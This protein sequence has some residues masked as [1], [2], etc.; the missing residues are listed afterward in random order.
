MITLVSVFLLAVLLVASAAA[1]VR[2]ERAARREYETAGE[3][4]ARDLYD[5]YQRD[6]EALT[7]AYLLRAAPDEEWLATLKT[8]AATPG[9]PGKD[10]RVAGPVPAHGVSGYRP[11]ST[12][13]RAA[14]L[15]GTL[16][17][18]GVAVGCGAAG[19]FAALEFAH[20]GSALVVAAG[21]VT[22]VLAAASAAP[23][24]MLLARATEGAGDRLTNLLRARADAKA[25][26]MTARVRIELARAGLDPDRTRQAA[27]MLRL[28]AA[29]GDP[30][31]SDVPDS[32]PENPGTAVGKV[33]RDCPDS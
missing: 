15:G 26:V 12:R 28:L 8:A 2:G 13:P 33:I 7:R 17:R 9:Q 24:G 6:V 1:A 22:A 10:T 21:L 23:A 20:T 30:P 29:N 19:S 14:V 27:E 32:G 5:R 31:R 11:A 4:M 3:A 25:T 16:T 18:A